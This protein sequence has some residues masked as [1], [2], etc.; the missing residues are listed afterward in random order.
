MAEIT[1]ATM[2]EQARALLMDG[3][4]AAWDDVTMM[5][6]ARQ[7]AAEYSLASGEPL[8]IEGLNAAITTLVPPFDALIVW[9]TS[10]YAALAKSIDKVDAFDVEGVNADAAEA[11]RG[12]GEARLLEYKS[13]LRAVHPG[14]LAETD[15]GERAAEKARRASLRVTN[16]PPWGQ[17]VFDAARASAASAGWGWL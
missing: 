8:L 2:I 4:G 1:L 13:M 17:W 12:W 7:A 15:A 16:T 3:S 5:A 14:Y 10:A 6:A 11:L 9:G